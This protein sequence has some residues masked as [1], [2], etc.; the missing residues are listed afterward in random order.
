MKISR[1]LR[2]V[3]V[4]LCMAAIF[5]F[6]AQNAEESNKVS[7]GVVEIIE[8][9]VEPIVKDLDP[10][11]RASFMS[12]LTTFVRKSAHFFI[13]AL[14]GASFVFALW[15]FDHKR[16]ILLLGVS[17]L[18]S[19]VYACTDELHQSFVGG[20]GPAFTDVLLDTAGAALGAAL[21][22]LIFAGIS[23]RKAKR[24]ALQPGKGYVNEG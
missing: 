22:Y 2:W 12:D 5:S 20:R 19:F 8:P 24:A 15:G 17:V 11:S 18:L 7:S 16:R 23:A 4:I 21:C 9:I 1:L 3:P 6:S 13:Y 14:L 10:V